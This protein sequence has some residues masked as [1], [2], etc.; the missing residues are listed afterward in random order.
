MR[1]HSFQAIRNTKHIFFCAHSLDP[2]SDGFPK[3]L[4]ECLGLAHF[5]GE[6]L[7]TSQCC[8]GCVRAKRLGDACRKENLS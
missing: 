7:T 4:A 3:S 2:H 1:N 8:E 6:D 5:Q